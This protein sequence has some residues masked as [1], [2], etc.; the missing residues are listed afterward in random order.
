MSEWLSKLYLYLKFPLFNIGSESVSLLSLVKFLAVF[1]LGF[2]LGRLFRTKIGRL[3]TKAMEPENL[4]IISNIGYYVIVI[5]TVIVG[6]SALGINLSSL[7]F[8]AGAV[9]VGVGF[10]L[11]NIVSNFISGIILMFEKTVRVGDLVELPTK[12][13]GYVKRINMR[14]TIIVTSDNIEIIVPNQT[15][16][17]Q[18]IVNFSYSDNIYR[19]KVPFSAAYGSDI[20]RVKSVVLDKIN[21]SNL[22]FAREKKPV[23][24]LESLGAS[25]LDF[26][27]VVYIKTGLNEVVPFHFD[28]LPLIYDA[29][30][31][32]GISI[33]FPQAD[34]HI[35]TEQAIL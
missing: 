9:S 24:L 10:G 32:A 1:W 8:V 23:V 11:Q 33:P 2:Y 28:F 27:L 13:R 19:L 30:N 20:E 21:N 35:K 18:N 3:Q 4:T 34:I 14:S 12:E 15:F 6:L 29:L 31:A 17:T 26:S 16:I 7:A 5:G 25:S 22:R